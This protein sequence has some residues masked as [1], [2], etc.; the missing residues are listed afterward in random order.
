MATR[1]GFI[2]TGLIATSHLENLATME[3]VEIAGLCDVSQANLE[4]AQKRFGGRAYRDHGDMLVT[5]KPDA[6]YVC[7]P[8]F[9]HAGQEL[10][11]LAAGA[12]LFVEKPVTLDLEKGRRIAVEIERRHAV[13][14]CG[15]HWR[16]A[17]GADRA[18]E[19]LKPEQI[20]QV[21]GRWLGGIW[22]APWWKNK[23]QSGGQIVEQV[24]HLFDLSRYLAGEISEVTAYAT[25]GQVRDV[26]GY[27][28]D[29]ASVVNVR[30]ASGAVG[31]FAQTCILSRG[32]GA[33]LTLIGRDLALQYTTNSLKVTRPESIAEYP[34]RAQ[35]LSLEDQ[36]F[37]AA[38]RSG[39][40]SG[41]RSTYHDALQT[42]TATLAA[43]ASLAQSGRQQVVERWSFRAAV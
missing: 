35:A 29:D 22:M 1:I 26:E 38:V 15:Y 12:A 14:C 7:I 37:V 4:K 34:A 3:G 33:D 17:D 2:G 31:N 41:L 28:L 43:N 30:Y 10:D 5:E 24:T 25:S 13:A 23:E 40:S 42:V 18:R 19:T 36:A 27:T 39:D 6:V 32:L 11:V 8:P 16:Y 9:A 21:L 20:V